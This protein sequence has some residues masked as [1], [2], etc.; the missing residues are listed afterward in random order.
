[1]EF[2]A[3]KNNFFKAARYGMETKFKWMGKL[4][5]AGDLI[6][7][8]LLPMARK[9]LLK[10]DINQAD[11][12]LYLGIIE[13]RIKSKNGAQW[14]IKSYR[15]LQNT[16][17]RFESRQQLT[18]FMHKHQFGDKTVDEWSELNSIELNYIK[19]KKIVK[20]RMKTN[21]FMV[22]ESDS[23]ELVSHIMQ[24]KNIHHLPVINNQ[25]ELTGL[26]TWT[27]L[28]KLGNLDLK[29]TVKEAM[30]TELITISQEKPLDKA[31]QIMKDHHINCL[32]VVH[33]KKLLGIL[34]TND[35][36]D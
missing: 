12:D 9:G 8:I 6:S 31:K 36:K 13:N 27:D 25:K 33:K 14:M 28:I 15:N 2:R 22:Y 32:P 16:K 35:F 19:Q 18:A 17:T 23:L 7:K 24:W 1:M 34:T 21:L 4:I 11:I 10:S 20:H 5:S 26:I 29:F 30:Q 3:V